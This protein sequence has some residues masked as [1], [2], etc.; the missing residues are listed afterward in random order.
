MQNILVIS[1]KKQSGKTSLVNFLHGYEMRRAGAIKAFDINDSG[2]LLVN[3]FSV[4]ADGHNVDGVGV[5]DIERKDYDFERYAANQIW[6]HIKVY[7]F[8]DELKQFL[9]RHFGLTWEQ[10]YGTNEQKES[11]TPFRWSDFAFALPT[12]FVGGLKKKKV[13]S[14]YM[15]AREVM[16]IFG[17]DVCRRIFESCW[18]KPTLERI[19]VENV[20]LAIITDAR[21]I[22]EIELGKNFGAR[23]LRLARCM[24]ED[25]H[26]SENELNEYDGFDAILDNRQITMRQKNHAAFAILQGWG[27]IQG[28]I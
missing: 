18:S 1:G 24:Y 8:A 25:A 15:S 9:I 2:Q 21:F 5:L 19:V 11:K 26:S 16:Q 3:T 7:S 17:T 23:T 27:F 13:Y 4:D 6:P 22:S 28:D 20:P 14:E 10:C 12:A